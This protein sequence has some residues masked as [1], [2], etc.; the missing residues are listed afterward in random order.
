MA[1]IPVGSV[2]QVHLMSGAAL[3]G[4]LTEIDSNCLVLDTIE[5]EILL[6]ADSIWMIRRRDTAPAPAAADGRLATPVHDLR[7]AALP[8]A[9]LADLRDRALRLA[10]TVPP[11]SFTV[12]TTGYDSETARRIKSHMDSLRDRYGYAVKMKDE[13]RV[14]SSVVGLRHFAEVYDIPSALQIGGRIAWL[15]GEKTMALELFAQAADT[16]NDSSSCFDLAMAQ[17]MTDERG[18]A[19]ATLAGCLDSESIAGSSPAWLALLASVLREAEGAEELAGVVATAGGWAPGAG[20]LGALH[21]G[22]VCADRARISGFSAGDWTSPTVDAGAFQVVARAL[23]AVEQI[24]AAPPARPVPAVTPVRPAAVGKPAITPLAVPSKKTRPAVGSS[25]RPHPTPA[26]PPKRPPITTDPLDNVPCQAAEIRTLLARG[27]RAAASRALTMLKAAAPNHAETWALD[28]LL[29]NRKAAPARRVSSPDSGGPPAVRSASTEGG[30]YAQAQEAAR[31]GDTATARRLLLAEI[32]HGDDPVRAVKRLVVLLNTPT[33]REDA[34]QLLDS[35]R[36]LFVTEDDRWR[37]SQLRST[38]LEHMG[39]WADASVELANMLTPAVKGDERVRLVS[40]LAMALLHTFRQDEA[41]RLLEIELRRN[42]RQETI[43]RAFNQLRQAMQSGVYSKVEATLQV[44][45][46]HTQ[47]LSSVLT[48][49]LDRCTYRGVRAEAIA[50]GNFTEEDIRRLDDLVSGKSK[51][52]AIGSD[53]PRERAD[54]NLSAARIMRDLGIN[55]ERFRSRLRYFAAAMGDACAVEGTVPADVIRTY[56]AE[57]VSVKRDWDDLVDVKLRQLV[58]S[59][60][61]HDSRLLEMAQLPGLE[62]SLIRTMRESHLSRPVLLTLLRLPTIGATA[63][64]L[65]RRIWADKDTRALFQEALRGYLEPTTPVADESKFTAAWIE[66][67]TRTRRRREELQRRIGVLTDLVATGL[68]ALDEHRTELQAIATDMAEVG[69][70]TEVARVNDCL[71]VIA[72]LR[73]YYVQTAYVERERLYGF[74][75]RTIN[76]LVGEYER[77]PTPTSLE[78]MVPYLRALEEQLRSHF[79]EYERG[80]EPERLDVEIVVDRF[81]LPDGEVHIQL[82]VSNAPGT[83][84]VSN[85]VLTVLPSEDYVETGHQ[86]E[87]AAS[88]AAGESHICPITLHASDKAIQQQ[89]I[90]LHCEISFTLRSQQSRAARVDPKS[91]RLHPEAAW[92]EIENPYNAGPAVGDEKMF[93]GRD[94]LLEELAAAFSQPNQGSIVVYGQKRAGKSSVLLHLERRLERPNIAVSFSM[95]E[96]AGEVEFAAVL[97]KIGSE[98]QN[99]LAGLAEEE[100]PGVTPP[101]RPDLLDIRLSPQQMFIEYMRDLRRWMRTVP[102]LADGRLVLL[103]DEFSMLHRHIR[104]GAVTEDFMK[105]WK[106]MLEAGLFRCVL[107]GNDLMPRFIS[108]FPNEFQVARQERVSY[109]DTTAAVDLIVSPISMPDGTSRYRGNAVERILKLT[110]QSPYYIQLFCQRLV[111]YMNSD[112]VRGVAIGPADVEAVAAKMVRGRESLNEN[113]FDNLLTPG[114]KD[115]TDI[116]SELAEEVLRATAQMWGGTM[117]HE[118]PKG[119]NTHPK[120]E[121]VLAD[122]LRREVLERASGG[123]YRI[124]VGLFAEWLQHRWA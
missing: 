117:M 2:V 66:A 113:E 123:R 26:P 23:G 92:T 79:A 90:T 22:L 14:H 49:H 9:A 115:A 118:A 99:R 32:D 89:L 30:L 81:L 82:E 121:Y 46:G 42:P 35:H 29:A 21:G 39:K 69:T 88:I 112:G 68:P 6:E 8:E 25:E 53:T 44:Q 114:D 80:A 62:T 86:V 87:V 31:R 43:R 38:I 59:F 95:L 4:T 7:P 45:A 67:A 57:A 20:R 72:D 37:W 93:K 78:L 124:R 63:G 83:S 119:K 11:V 71:G 91:I 13:K 77:A 10:L 85:V 98:C 97:Y 50:S 64:R 73:E 111:Q 16:L 41:M 34:L 5:G 47:E 120:A 1:R 70:A 116:S 28:R 74:A 3:D 61:V 18:L 55:G 17:R 24:A 54:Y 36:E 12:D 84:P 33:H 102:G 94:H 110:G 104:S 48:F 19:P 106:A 60:L 51:N 76:T 108:E 96:L 75:M 56:Y 65:I 52:R 105:G 40:R 27:D 107:V 15:L 101:G 103:I 58:Q 100:E 122:L 109:L